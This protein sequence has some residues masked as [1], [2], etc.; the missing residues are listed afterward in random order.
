MIL[1]KLTL[2]TVLMCIAIF[3]IVPLLSLAKA[4]KW[5]QKADM[6]T[7]R[8]ALSTSTVGGKIYA[9][10]GTPNG[11]DGLG[12]VEVYDPVTDTWTKAPNMP[13]PRGSLSASAVK[14][15][16]YAIGGSQGGLLRRA[17]PTVEAYNTG[18]P[19]QNVQLKRKL[20][21]IWGKLKVDE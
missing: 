17:L 11:R 1:R 19:P 7:A 21:T 8:F 3:W 6:P 15:K 12:S 20:A 4:G 14:G 5:R 10:G 9:V 16:V 18:V 2:K 13:T